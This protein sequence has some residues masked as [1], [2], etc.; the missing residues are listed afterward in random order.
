MALAIPARSF[1]AVQQIR[2]LIERVQAARH[3]G[4]VSVRRER[5]G[6]GHD[7]I[8]VA[9]G[10]GDNPVHQIAPRR[11]KL[12]IDPPNDL[13]IG[14][15]TVVGLREGLRK[16]VSK[17]VT[18]RSGRGTTRAAVPRLLTWMPSPHRK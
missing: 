11:N 8:E 10:H 17:C 5:S 14:E 12:I 1:T 13:V 6:R 15:I 3:R 9:I 2:D 16:R 7:T 18:A 4:L